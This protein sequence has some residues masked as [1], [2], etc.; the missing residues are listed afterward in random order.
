MR[1][2]DRPVEST[3]AR[4]AEAAGYEFIGKAMETIAPNAFVVKVTRQ[5]EGVSDKWV[6]A[7]KGRIEAGDLNG[8]R[9]RV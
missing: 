5:R 9:K 1:D 2:D 8:P 3:G 6:A 4:S 7:M